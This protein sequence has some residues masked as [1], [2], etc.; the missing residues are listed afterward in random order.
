MKKILFVCLGN[1]CRSPAAENLFRH[2]VA[3]EGLQS[4]FVCD[5]AGTAGY[6]TGAPPDRRMREAAAKRGLEFVGAARQFRRQ[7]FEEFDLILAMDKSNYR[8]IRQLDPRGDFQ[9]KVKMMCDFCTRHREREV[10]DPYYGGPEGFERV[11]DLLEDACQGLLQ[12][13]K[14]SS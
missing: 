12:F 6:H 14:Q 1:I 10:P 3:Q 9:D 8:D 5:S 4:Q 11:L 13:L 7:D 2:L